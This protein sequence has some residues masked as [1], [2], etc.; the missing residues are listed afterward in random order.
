M[1]R[2]QCLVLL[3][4]LLEISMSP[5]KRVSYCQSANFA[6]TAREQH[7]AHTHKQLLSILPSPKRNSVRDQSSIRL[8]KIHLRGRRNA[9]STRSL[10]CPDSRPMLLQITHLGRI[11][12]LANFPHFMCRNPHSILE[13]RDSNNFIL[14]FLDNFTACD[15]RYKTLSF[16]DLDL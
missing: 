7:S 16:T 2:E 5:F 13:S 3:R 14:F 4:P 6:E 12:R 8:M 10:P 9:V 11:I 1:L 15:N